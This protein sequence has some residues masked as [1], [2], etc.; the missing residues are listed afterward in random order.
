MQIK[1]TQQLAEYLEKPKKV[2]KKNGKIDTKFYNEELL[3]LHLELVKLQKWIIDN[4]KRLLI[5]F[6]TKH[7]AYNSSLIR[8]S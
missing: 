3:K 7:P 1:Y 8:A 6:I 5:I 2:F 4:E